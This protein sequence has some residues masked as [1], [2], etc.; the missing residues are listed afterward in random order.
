MFYTCINED[1]YVY[2]VTTNQKEAL[3]CLDMFP[4]DTILVSVSELYAY[5]DN[6]SV[7]VSRYNA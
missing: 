7:S 1:G 4:M 2:R 3:E 6:I 5:G